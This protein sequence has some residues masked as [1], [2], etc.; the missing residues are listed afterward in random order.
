M[1]SLPVD[2]EYL[3][4]MIGISTL[5]RRNRFITFLLCK[6]FPRL[7]LSKPLLTN[8]ILMKMQH[9]SD[10]GIQT[11][12]YKCKWAFLSVPKVDGIAV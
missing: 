8:G 10:D 5:L 11:G 1:I 3:Y 7:I 2:L 6:I 9:G 12:S 4:E